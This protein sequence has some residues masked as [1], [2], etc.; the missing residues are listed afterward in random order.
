[1]KI[2]NGFVSNSS[3]SSFIIP[4]DKITD[5]QKQM[6]YNHI[7][8]GQEIDKKLK[9]EGK[10]PTYE[11]YEDWNIKE[12]EYALWCS[13]SMNNFDL[14]NFV[15]KVVK[16]KKKD[17]DMLGDGEY[18]YELYEDPIYIEKKNIFLRGKKLNQL[19]DKLS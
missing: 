5:E 11:Y 16:V 10:E 4:L 13:T 6:I 19:K 8:I 12:D 17:I 9:E 1:M 14:Y 7:V 18:W 15:R 3:A 2:R